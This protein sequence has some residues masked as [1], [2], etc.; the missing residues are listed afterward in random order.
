MLERIGESALREELPT[1]GVSL[2]KNNTDTKAGI[3]EDM[4]S[5]RE[6]QSFTTADVNQVDVIRLGLGS[7]E[8]GKYE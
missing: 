8:K 5:S 3:Q 6:L 4:T 7:A 2:R 1:G